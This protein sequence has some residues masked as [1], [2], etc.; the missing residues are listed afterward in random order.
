MQAC[1][2][3][4][5]EPFSSQ[6]LYDVYF[7]GVNYILKNLYQ[8]SG[9]YNNLVFDLMRGSKVFFLVNS[10]D[11]NASICVSPSGS[12][13]IFFHKPLWEIMKKNQNIF[14]FVVFHEISHR[15][16]GADQNKADTLAFQI[17]QANGYNSV[18]PEL[19]QFIK[20]YA[21]R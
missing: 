18:D 7:E 14:A 20:I 5:I 2:M 13:A 8:D 9:E 17:M 4:S 21:H 6:E 10:P 1:N 12:I 19:L 15:V 3:Q 16:V 11:K